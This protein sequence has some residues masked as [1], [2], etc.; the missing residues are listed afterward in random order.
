MPNPI[1]FIVGLKWARTKEH[2]VQ[3]DT[4][5]SKLAW[6]TRPDDGGEPRPVHVGHYEE[7]D[8][9][10]TR[11]QR[12][13]KPTTPGATKA[14]HGIKT[15]KEGRYLCCDDSE[16]AVSVKVI[17][18]SVVAWHFKRRWNHGANRKY[19]WKCKN[20]SQYKGESRFHNVTTRAIARILK[21]ES[22]F[23][24]KTIIETRWEILSHF[25]ID[26]EKTVS[27]KPD[28]YVKFSDNSWFA[29]EVVFTSD[30]TRN[31]HDAYG[32]N[33]VVI[34]LKELNVIESDQ[35]FNKWVRDGGIEKA[36][37]IESS[38]EKRR[39][40]FK[41]RQQAFN[42]Q[43]E[44]EFKAMLQTEYS[45]CR[46]KFGFSVEIDFPNVSEVSEI[47]EQFNQERDRRALFAEINKTIEKNVE[48]YGERLDRPADEFT[49]VKEVNDYYRNHFAEKMEERK[50]KKQEYN[51]NIKE[52]ESEFGFTTDGTDETWTYEELRKSFEWQK[53]EERQKLDYDEHMKK[54][55]SEFG[56]TIPD[57]DKT[58]T[59]EELRKGF[60]WQENEERNKRAKEAADKEIKRAKEAADKIQ[61]REYDEHIKEL[62]SEFGFTT[63][64]TDETWTYEELRSGFVWQKNNENREKKI[65]ANRNEWAE[66][67]KNSQ[68]EHIENMA[69]KEL[70]S[71]QEKYPWVKRELL[72]E[73]P[74]ILVD[75]GN[76]NSRFGNPFSRDFMHPYGEKLHEK[77]KSVRF[78]LND[79]ET[80]L[81]TIS[82]ELC[83]MIEHDAV[84]LDI[85]T[86]YKEVVFEPEKVVDTE[87]ED[88]SIINNKCHW[89][90]AQIITIRT[91]MD[92]SV[93]I[94]AAN[95]MAEL[96]L[97][98]GSWYDGLTGDQ[99]HLI[100]EFEIP[101]E[102]EGICVKGLLIP[103]PQA[104]LLKE[105][106]L[107]K[108]RVMW[109]K[110]ISETTLSILFTIIDTQFR[111]Q[112]E[113]TAFSK[114][115]SERYYTPPIPLD[116]T[117]FS[118]SIQNFVQ[119]CEE[120]F[121][122]KLTIVV[123][124]LQLKL[125]ILE[126]CSG[127]MAELLEIYDELMRIHKEQN[128]LLKEHN[129]ILVGE[130][131]IREH[132]IKLRTH[133]SI[134]WAMLRPV[135][136][137]SSR[138]N[139]IK[140]VLVNPPLSILDLFNISPMFFIFPR[141]ERKEKLL[142]S[143]EENIFNSIPKALDRVIQARRNKGRISDLIDTTQ[144]LLQSTRTTPHDIFV[145]MPYMISRVIEKTD[146]L[147]EKQK[148][149]FVT[150][151]RKTKY[152]TFYSD[153]IKFGTEH[154]ES[155][156]QLGSLIEH[157][158]EVSTNGT[159]EIGDIDDLDLE[160]EEIAILKNRLV[161][162]EISD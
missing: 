116:F 155:L 83:E 13:T 62:E 9:E 76:M 25:E 136:G 72:E 117:P 73:V 58:W 75:E 130:E 132:I 137:S 65:A 138:K 105:M 89:M 51:K 126:S 19:Q 42:R 151:S 60:E 147:T 159:L 2:H 12:W 78:G 5:H 79:I 4:D 45:K 104:K 35:R 46:E 160:E 28:V 18:A 69:I 61:K 141:M 38:L 161:E 52:L 77:A 113:W 135:F 15:F 123:E 64:G 8:S 121:E 11:K 44:K 22:K 86:E 34:D 93:L 27:L 118:T 67:A 103:Q 139:P 143:Q 49:S 68:E 23:Q 24:G 145:A 92:N 10:E 57:T 50:L 115:V 74:L 134:D 144:T 88:Y 16:C 26:G 127:E 128:N 29:I 84:L 97:E 53:E 98:L 70:A 59:Y 148:E 87:K 100:E 41:E 31:A 96:K 3:K 37:E 55:E 47:K 158:L 91:L 20:E 133:F 152:Q 111:I 66:Q 120:N 157:F 80:L 131:M 54:L 108:R 63:D 162:K 71:A 56:F 101:N 156:E 124:E 119:D 40:R 1:K 94:E 82:K 112:E 154:N 21:P 90:N 43:D 109:T 114:R 125:T 81:H 149:G 140:K 30:P 14:V 7:W 32:T 48:K 146:L 102:F 110:S 107:R 122:S 99:K 36:L 39:L 142:I 129:L 85:F 150:S 33:M 153:I 106:E 95:Q 6:D 17:Q